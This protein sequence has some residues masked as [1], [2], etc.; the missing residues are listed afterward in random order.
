MRT[1]VQLTKE[2]DVIVDIYHRGTQQLFLSGPIAVLHTPR[3]PLSLWKPVEFL[4]IQSL[5]LNC[6]CQIRLKRS[7]FVHFT[8]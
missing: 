1:A 3:P 6:A 2:A 8:I 7:N 5:N 4:K